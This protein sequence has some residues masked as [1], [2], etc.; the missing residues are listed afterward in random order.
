M[1][2]PASADYYGVLGLGSDASPDEIK[3]AYRRL[4]RE[5]HPDANP[6]DAEAEARFK[7]IALA[8]ETLSDPERRRRYDMFGPEG[9]ASAAGGGPFGGGGGFGD[10]F[11]M[12]FGGQGFGGQPG[13]AGPPRGVD[14]EAAVTVDFAEAVF[15]TQSPVTVRT[16]I[17]CDTCEASGCAPGT[18]AQRCEECDGVGQVRR[19][20]QS[21]LGQ[22]VTASPCP[23]CGGAGEWIEHRCE[24]CAGEGR[25][26]EERTYTI[27][28]PAGIDDGQTL[29]LPGRGAVGPRGGGTGDLFVGVRVRPHERF[30]RHG[31]D[32]HCDVMVPMVQAALGA[33]LEIELLDGIE[34]LVIEPGTVSGAEVRFRGRGV[35]RVDGRGRGDVRVRV[36]VEIPK[37]LTKEED[38]LLRQLAEL[39]GHEV[40]APG[41]K[42]FS[43]LKSAFT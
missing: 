31:L 18:F 3:R 40:A 39:Q 29:R 7:E 15:G 21:L 28:I 8:Y 11:E 12:F 10:I 9:A 19:V 27:D 26:V 14:L 4:A 36:L 30:E 33:E 41:K 37:K 6:G 23:R 2:A 16:A 43:K 13:S 1:S 34:P 5:H 24:A 42:R 25:L 22:M 32:L 35:P 38:E 17:P 20:R